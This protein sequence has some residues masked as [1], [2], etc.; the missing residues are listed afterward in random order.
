MTMKT[1][2]ASVHSNLKQ[3]TTRAMA[4]SMKVGAMVNNICFRAVNFG[5]VMVRQLSPLKYGL[6][7]PPG[8]KHGEFP[9]FCGGCGRRKKVEVNGRTQVETF[10]GKRDLAQISE[11]I[12]GYVP[13][14]EYCITGVQRH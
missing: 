5:T 4:M 10:L 8:L 1:T 14:S 6:S 3:K 12:K 13:R 9:Q 7:R 11:V 2:S